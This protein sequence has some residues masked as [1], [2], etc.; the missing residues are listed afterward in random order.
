MKHGLVSALLAAVMVLPVASFAETKAPASAASQVELKDGS[1]V[2]IEG[3]NVSVIDA[4]GKKA[5]APDGTHIA[6]DGQE[7]KTKDGKIVR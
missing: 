3:D 7:I 4:S 1:K 5:P 2:Q 6:K